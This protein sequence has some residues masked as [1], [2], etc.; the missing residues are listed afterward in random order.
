M[1]ITT[2]T[3]TWMQ[4]RTCEHEHDMAIQLSTI[5]WAQ[6]ASQ[7]HPAVQSPI[8]PTGDS[9]RQPVWVQWVQVHLHPPDA[10][11]WISCSLVLTLSSVVMTTMHSGIGPTR[12]AGIIGDHQTSK[13]AVAIDT[14]LNQKWWNDSKDKE[15]K[16]Y[17]VCITVSQK[18]PT[19]IAQLV[20]TLKENVASSHRFSPHF[21]CPVSRLLFLPLCMTPSYV[22]FSDNGWLMCPVSCA[23]SLISPS[24][25]DPFICLILWQWTVDVP[26][27]SFLPLR[28][29]PS[30]VLFSDNGRLM[31]PVSCPISHA[32]SLI[33]PPIS[34]TP[35]KPL[36]LC[37]HAL[38][39]PPS[40]VHLAH[41]SHLSLVSLMPCLS[42]AIFSSDQPWFCNQCHTQQWQ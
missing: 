5:I 32:P 12:A 40:L 13:T 25:H 21:L 36:L 42:Q 29:T 22:L 18:C 16:L 27:L 8:P 9:S 15:K 26:C 35:C 20:K 38:F 31:W 33:S 34:C 1:P 41:L 23:L 6:A 7:S 24:S 3:Q 4:T 37:S 17:C 10:P 39:L 2:P 28:M 30:Y 19:A 14:I 11:A